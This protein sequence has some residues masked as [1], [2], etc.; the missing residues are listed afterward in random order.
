MTSVECQTVFK[1]TQ[2]QGINNL[3]E[4]DTFFNFKISSTSTYYRT[5]G[6]MEAK[7]L[8]ALSLLL[9]VGQF[10]G[11]HNQNRIPK[12]SFFPVSSQWCIF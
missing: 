6:I 9:A 1:E 7:L 12:Y 5:T 8:A 3:S 4:I 11:E 2:L 10:T